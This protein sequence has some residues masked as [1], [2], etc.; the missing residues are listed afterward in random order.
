MINILT[1][2]VIKILYMKTGPFTL[3]VTNKSYS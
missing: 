2:H 3:T 1:Y